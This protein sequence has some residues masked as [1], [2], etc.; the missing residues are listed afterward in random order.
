MTKLNLGCMAVDRLFTVLWVTGKKCVA[1]PF[2]INNCIVYLLI[3]GLKLCRATG[4]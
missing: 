3:D 2:D 1:C 4:S